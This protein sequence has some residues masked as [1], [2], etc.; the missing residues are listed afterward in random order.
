LT[1]F[2]L[3]SSRNANP[4]KQATM[5]LVYRFAI[6][7]TPEQEQKLFHVFDLCRKLYNLALEQRNRHYKETGQGLSYYDQQKQLPSFKAKH[8]EYQKVPSQSL[9]DVLRRLDHAFQ[10]FFAKRA[11]FPRF[12]DK[13]R[14]RSITIPQSKP[15]RNFGRV[16]YIYIPKIGH[17]LMHAHRRFD[18]A[19]VK[20]INVKHHNGKWHVNLTA[21]V[22]V[23][24]PQMNLRQAVGVNMGLHDVAVTSEGVHYDNPR[25]IYRSEKKMRKLQRG[26]S[27]KKKGSRNRMRAKVKLQCLHDRI[28][29][30]RKDFLHKL[31]FGM[32]QAYDLICIE[33]LS[34]QG[35]MKN[36]RLAKSIANASW[37]RLAKYL[38]YKSMKYGKRWVKVPP[39]NTE[40]THNFENP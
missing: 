13:F 12:K 1:S 15:K 2:A 25:W 31:S 3:T 38:E 16:G 19:T 11:G 22:P 17:I 30:Q 18:P 36:H 5:D 27:K 20:I 21:E 28:A 26:L 10:N 6:E 34:V 8:P 35:M 37:H 40:L 14:L 9:Q 32:V 24:D 33:D 23:Q 39:E 29:N 4:D 7:P